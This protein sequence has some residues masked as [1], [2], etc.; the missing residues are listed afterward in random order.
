[1][2]NIGSI[3]SKSVGAMVGGS[4]DLQSPNNSLGIFE[5]I[6][7]TGQPVINGDILL[8]TSASLTGVGIGNP[9]NGTIDVNVRE[10]NLMLF[11]NLQAN[12]RDGA[13]GNISLSAASI[14][15][16]GTLKA[17]DDIFIFSQD[18]L[19]I[20]DLSEKGGY[21]LDAGRDVRLATL[22]TTL[23][24]YGDI[25]AGRD[26]SAYIM[27]DNVDPVELKVGSLSDMTK[28]E[29]GR[30][31]SFSIERVA[32]EREAAGNITLQAMVS[33]ETGSVAVESDIGEIAVSGNIT[34]KKDIEL[35]SNNG[36]VMVFDRLNSV[37]GDIYAGTKKGNIVLGDATNDD[38][39][40]VAYQDVSIETPDG[41]MYINGKTEAQNGNVSL[42]A[43]RDVYT[44]GEEDSVFVI[45]NQ[46]KV[47][48]GGSLTLKGRN[49]DIFVTDDL[50]ATTGF[51]AD[52]EGHGAINF[53]KDV[54]VTGDI[55]GKT[56]SGDITICKNIVS[57]QGDITLYTDNGDISVL[58]TVHAIQGD[59]S[60]VSQQGNLTMGVNDRDGLGIIANDNIELDA[61]AGYINI[62]G[63]VQAKEGVLNLHAALPAGEYQK[64]EDS[65]SLL[66]AGFGKI[67][68]GDD[69]LLH[70]ENGDMFV[71]DS[72]QV[73]K[74]LTI[75]VDKSGG[76]YFCD[77]VVV[78][79]NLLATTEVGDI[80]VV[81][82]VSAKGNVDL[83]TE[84]GYI[85]VGKTLG[86]VTG[87]VSLVAGT[88]DIIIGLSDKLRQNLYATTGS[89][90]VYTG[91]GDILI[92]DNGS[93]V[94]TIFAKQN[95][96]LR[97]DSGAV[98]VYGRTVT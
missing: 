54:V 71:T 61:M 36:S 81:E 59:V 6:A 43:G 23:A 28:I 55:L 92:G 45:N 87:D 73:G 86:A 10:G 21:T 40:V 16:L 89:V 29:A 33:S 75:D 66:V 3:S 52:I 51:V 63:T 26:I 57:R 95:I 15:G 65:S 30:D 44:S 88:G 50:M 8:R 37:T 97:S 46:G 58:D 83:Q 11:G 98:K 56:E 47:V 49:G 82:H 68:S 80:D 1:V 85:R 60:I 32:D 42:M 96:G 62:L 4:V 9:V 41:V 24:I 76:L 2:Q 34:A 70:L 19:V 79:G 69:M 64:G 48:A 14:L 13:E 77:N 5:A 90:E 27:A 39:A 31:V 53:G 25:R 74:N 94:D 93:T 78:N 67:I 38:D 17:A 35:T 72:I 20:A 91:K 22:D 12:G 84:K 7:R 18:G